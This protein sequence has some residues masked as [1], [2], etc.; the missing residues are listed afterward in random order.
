MSPALTLALA[1]VRGWTR[2]YT[3]GLPAAE[4]D[5]RRAEIDSDLWELHED[6]RRR[7]APPWWIAA[8]MICRVLL[9]FG[10]DIGWR[11]ERAPLS[12]RFVQDTLWAAAA[13]SVAFVW[14]LASTL[15]ALEP[16]RKIRTD[17]IDVVRLLY[18]QRPVADVPAMPQPPPGFVRL[19]RTVVRRYPPPPPPPPPPKPPRK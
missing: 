17:G 4:R 7:H 12:M 19:T 16:P 8:H 15:Q 9:G 1:I 14:W 10:H 3:A 6:A 5:A 2:V 11:A 13:A 18:R